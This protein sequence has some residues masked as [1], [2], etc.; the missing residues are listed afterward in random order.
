MKKELT[1]NNENI[2]SWL[3]VV[4]GAIVYISLTFNKNVWLDEAF[5]ASL[6]RT[7]MAGVIER[8]MADTLPPLY[9]IILKIS[10]DIFGY[11]VPVMKLT[12]V[13]PMII[14]MIVSAT[15]VRNPTALRHLHC[16]RL[17]YLQCRI[18][19]FSV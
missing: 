15:V 5:S 8:S 10:T 14:T 18:F 13:V 12:S 7:D 3:L 1:K 4:I 9:N 19:Y 2:I 11:S 6:V 16:S 17:L